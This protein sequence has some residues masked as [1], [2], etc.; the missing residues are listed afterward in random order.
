MHINLF[1]SSFLIV[2]VCIDTELFGHCLVKLVEE[3]CSENVQ[4]IYILFIIIYFS[5]H[6]TPVL[7]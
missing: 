7:P 2:L 1:V 6:S 3:I 4:I 5:I